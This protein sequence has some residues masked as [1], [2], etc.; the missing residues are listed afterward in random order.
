MLSRIEEWGRQ[1]LLI[2]ATY[3]SLLITLGFRVYEDAAI[4][5][6]AVAQ[7]YP[8]YFKQ[9]VFLKQTSLERVA[10]L[11]LYIW[12]ID[13]WEW[14]FPLHAAF[15]LM[16]IGGLWR[17]ARSV[18]AADGWAWI[19]VW[20]I[21]PGLYHHHWGSNELYYPQLQPS[22]LAKAVGVWLWVFLLNGRMKL[23][24]IAVIIATLFH[25]SVGFLTWGFSLPL[26]LW[27]PMRRWGLYAVASAVVLSYIFFLFR[28]STIPATERALWERLFVDFRM[29]MHFDPS[30][31]RS[32]S[33]GLFLALWGV[34]VYGSWRRRS[35]LLGVFLLYGAG[36]FAYVL[37]F[38]T[39]R[40]SPLIYLQV[41][42]ATVW[43]KP[44]GAFVGIALIAQKWRLPEFS[45]RSAAILAGLIGWSAFRLSRKEEVGRSYLQVFRWKE[46]EAYQLGAWA[47][48]NLPPDALIANIPTEIGERAQFF[49]QRSGYFWLRATLRYEDPRL[50][51]QRIYRLYG[52]DAMK[53]KSAW[54]EIERNGTRHFEKVCQEN[55]DSLRSWGITHV[56]VSTSACLSM[57]PLWQ[58]KQIALYALE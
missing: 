1:A 13:R 31:F 21:L 7:K 17:L 35:P 45:F 34:G 27:Q 19:A 41:P 4:P 15:S 57:K 49:C 37:N 58:G 3:A 51:A 46:D 12:L 14:V 22:L 32:S 48:K 38:Y 26:L 39:L 47:R 2:G 44:L 54:Q 23:A 53:G 42:R 40:W 30:S 6:W 43:L 55:P 9:D 18:G 25:P 20:I 11:P 33:H 29:H 28:H 50:Y 24:A 5:P 36:V 52:V 56:I 10:I 8:E 16:L